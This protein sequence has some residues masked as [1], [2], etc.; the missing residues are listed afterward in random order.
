MDC[1]N[2]DHDESVEAVAIITLPELLG[3]SGYS[4]YAVCPPHL[5]DYV[6]GIFV[7]QYNPSLRLAF[8]VEPTP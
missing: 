8:T 3:Q 5:I 6:Q 7:D 2:Q 1:E 4:G